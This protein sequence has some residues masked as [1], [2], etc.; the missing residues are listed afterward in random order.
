M[1][2]SINACIHGPL[3]RTG[4]VCP[5]VLNALCEAQN[6]HLSS[7]AVGD[8]P[9]TRPAPHPCPSGVLFYNKSGSQHAPP[10]TSLADSLPLEPSLTRYHQREG[11]QSSSAPP[12]LQSPACRDLGSNL[13]RRRRPAKRSGLHLLANHFFPN[14]EGTGLHCQ[15]PRGP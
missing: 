2:P 9:W 6:G 8:C 14:P 5:A 3:P 12:P 7:G 11:S 10:R 1:P 4:G 13:P 15:R